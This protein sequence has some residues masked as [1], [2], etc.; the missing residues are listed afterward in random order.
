MITPKNEEAITRT[1]TKLRAFKSGAIEWLTW[2]GNGLFM[3]MKTPVASGYISD[4]TIA[5]F[6]NDGE[7]DLVYSVIQKGFLGKGQKSYIAAIKPQKS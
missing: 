1:L 2:N 7:D 5:D 6:D 4:L 3:K